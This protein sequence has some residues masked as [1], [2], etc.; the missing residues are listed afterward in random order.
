MSTFMCGFELC[1]KLLSLTTDFAFFNLT[2]QQK[3][4]K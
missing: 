4:N 3:S 2:N 1:A